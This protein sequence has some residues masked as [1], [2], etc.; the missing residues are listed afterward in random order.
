ME[1]MAEMGAM[2]ESALAMAG[3][4]AVSEM[5]GTE[6]MEAMAAAGAMAAAMV[7]VVATE[8]TAMAA[9]NGL[10]IRPQMMLWLIVG[11][12]PLAAFGQN[13]PGMAPVPRDALELATGQIQAA[14]PAGRDAALQ[15]LDRARNAYQLR[16]LRQAWD[17]KVRFT[18]NSFGATDYDGDWEMED[19]FAP[20]QGLHWTATSSAGYSISGIFA[21]KAIYADNAGKAVPL[22]LQEAR[23]MLFNPLPS[24][25]FAGNGS[26]RT[27]AAT[28]RGS[29]VTC[30]L[31]GRSGKAAAPATG[32]GWDEAEECIDS[33]SGLL[34]VHSEAPGRYAI[35][36]YSNAAQ[37]GSHR[38]PRT[39]TVTEGG[40]IVSKISV[41]SLQGIG[42]ADPGL[43]VPTEGMM[44][45]GQA[46]TMTS[47]TKVSRIQ[48]EGPYTASMMVR[49]VCVFGIV[50]PTGQL[51]EAHSLQPSD[52]NSEAAI[53]DAKAIDFSPSMPAGSPPQQHFVFVIEK[54]V[55]QE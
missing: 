16:N 28:F 26:I 2:A 12:L 34:Q 25:A 41:E 24:V 19:V 43:F 55:V 46:V 3:T 50:T 53:K 5:A 14:A 20:E 51:V 35:Y 32:R 29:A 13:A 54:F 45:S 9:Y 15:L 10:R 22:R 42:A 8:A 27:V 37:L 49:P 44:A 23:A 17:L 4:A 1:A 18:V 39:V 11:G 31:L 6:A 47:A 48:G 38:L 40:R 7:E 21:G 36:E 33:Q 30:L 52:P